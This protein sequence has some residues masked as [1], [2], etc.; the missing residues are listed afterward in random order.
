MSPRRAV[1]PFRRAS[2]PPVVTIR[3]AAASAILAIGFIG[4]P[5]GSRVHEGAG[6][7]RQA[8]T[9]LTGPAWAAVR[10]WR[11]A[12]D[13]DPDRRRGAEPVLV[14]RRQGEHIPAVVAPELAV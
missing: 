10:L 2:P 8:R 13:K 11:V 3:T 4:S 5:S 7:P 12:E 6:G 1:R 9:E 14:R